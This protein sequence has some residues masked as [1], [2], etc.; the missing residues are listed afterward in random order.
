M[1]NSSE[2]SCVDTPPTPDTIPPSVPTGL[3]ATAISSSQ[4]TLAWNASTDDV[5][6]TGVAGYKVYR[7][8][9]LVAASK[10]SAVIPIA[11]VTT[12]NY[13]DTGLIP[14]T[15]YCYQVSAFDGATPP[16]DS[17]QSDQVCART[18]DTTPPPSPDTTPPSVPAGLTAA[19]ISSGQIDLTWNTS[20]D[21]VGVTG[22]KVYRDGIFLKSVTTPSTSDT[23]LAP[24]TNHCYT[25][26]AFDA[27]NNESAQ[28]NP[29]CA[30][31]QPTQPPPSPFIDL[32]VPLVYDGCS[33]DGCLSFIV[34]NSGT[35]DATNVSI[36]GLNGY[37][38]F[39]TSCQPFFNITVPAGGFVFLDTGLFLLDDYYILIDPTN[40]ILESDEG[41]NALCSGLFCTTPPIW[42]SDFSGC[43]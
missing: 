29:A 1:T 8:G 42:P 7:N 41:N 34:Y 22:Y 35:M 23:G 40:A 36:Y 33:G 18:Q 17:A 11:T 24:S 20:T 39:P 13:S 12:T 4:I 6:G 5:G 19:A 21:D 15:Q 10:K 2:V 25:V 26:S 31:T 32:S 28:S 9:L 37:F 16:N 38:G 14:N 30:T 3:T 43:S 27:A